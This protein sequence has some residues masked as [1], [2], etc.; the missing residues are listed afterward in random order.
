MADKYIQRSMQIQVSDASYII[1]KALAECGGEL[2]IE[3]VISAMDQISNDLKHRLPA[4]PPGLNQS[5]ASMPPTGFVARPRATRRRV[6]GSQAPAPRPRRASHALSSRLERAMRRRDNESPARFAI[7]AG[8]RRYCVKGKNLCG[9][10]GRINT[11][12]FWF[13]IEFHSPL[14]GGKWASHARA[15]VV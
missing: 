15:R 11:L 9:R 2:C 7:R 10:L 5:L 13:F 12:V 1:R 3:A 14:R 4:L 8:A 6:D